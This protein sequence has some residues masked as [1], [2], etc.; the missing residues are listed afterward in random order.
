MSGAAGRPGAPFERRLTLL[1]WLNEQLGFEDNRELL[2]DLKHADEG[3]DSGAGRSHV[4][5]RLRS[6][7]VR[8]RVA[9]ADLDRYDGN[10]RRHL[11]AVN[12]G[13]RPPVRLRYFQHLAALHTEIVLD[14]RSRAPG[15]LLRSLND[16]VGRRNAGRVPGEAT[17]PGFERADLAK[18]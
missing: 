7:A 17:L 9:V 1:G 14:Q 5:S 8:P 10:I 16:F 6:R 11:D 13:R 3:F 12:R 2:G 15:E 18:L 4:V